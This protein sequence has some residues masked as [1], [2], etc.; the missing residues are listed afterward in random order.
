MIG[1]K[2]YDIFF[3]IKKKTIIF[4]K[5]TVLAV[6]D[7]LKSRNETHFGDVTSKNGYNF[8]SVVR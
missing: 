4:L 3:L 1:K 5:E 2:E 8:R 7:I 6:E